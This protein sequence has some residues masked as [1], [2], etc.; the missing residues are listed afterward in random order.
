MN[1]T[2]LQYCITQNGNKTK[3]HLILTLH[4]IEQLHTHTRVN[5]SSLRLFGANER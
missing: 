1:R 4:E 5:I 2:T 3:E